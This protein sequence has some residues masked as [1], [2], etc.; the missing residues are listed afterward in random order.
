M[1]KFYN[2]FV[3]TEYYNILR[4][5]KLLVCFLFMVAIG[6]ADQ[7]TSA[8]GAITP[9]NVTAGTPDQDFTYSLQFIGGTADSINITNPLH[10]HSSY[11]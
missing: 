7:A 2:Y 9:N 10:S 1:L 11:C 6:L 5:L 3:A 8:T 4:L